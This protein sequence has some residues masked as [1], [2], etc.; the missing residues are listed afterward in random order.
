MTA[1]L[2]V[3][4]AT[5]RDASAIAIIYNHYI[6][7]T[8]ITFELDELTEAD[9]AARVAKI[10]RAGLPWLVAEEDGVVLGY[11]YAGPFRERAAYLHTLE[12]SVYLDPDVRARGIGTALFAELFARLRALSPEQS[13]H[14][15]VHAVV[16]GVALP[17]E[18]SVALHERFDMTHVG[19]FTEVGWKFDHWI[20]VG[21][22]QVVLD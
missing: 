13:A 6:R 11:A 4:D 19:T 18:A 7:D 5:A 22:W 8:V 14:A 3:R 10:H 20:D 2:V 21:Y 16:G 15:P 12:A 17:N 9:M 1:G